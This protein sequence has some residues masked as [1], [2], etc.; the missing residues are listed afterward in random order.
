MFWLAPGKLEGRAGAVE[1]KERAGDT[2][3]PAR[4]YQEGRSW[5]RHRM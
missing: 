3:A 2:Y 5:L 1:A 4:D